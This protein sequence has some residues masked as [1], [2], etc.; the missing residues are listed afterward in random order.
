M[1]P[2]LERADTLSLEVLSDCPMTKTIKY[3]TALSQPT[4]MLAHSSSG[5]E[6]GRELEGS[7]VTGHP[8]TAR[9]TE[10]VLIKCLLYALEISTHTEWNYPTLRRTM[11][12]QVKCGQHKDYPPQD[13]WASLASKH[14]ER[15]GA[16]LKA[17]GPA[18]GWGRGLPVHTC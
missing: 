4:N 16:G 14:K 1:R 10:L 12:R 6:D 3:C 15:L 9:F 8:G 7:L 5:R 17:G 2:H 13:C 11:K 18:R